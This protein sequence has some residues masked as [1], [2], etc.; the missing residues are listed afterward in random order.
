MS[1]PGYICCRPT[2]CSLRFSPDHPSLG[3]LSPA[4]QFNPFSPPT[5]LQR[6]K[7]LPT[8]LWHGAAVEVAANLEAPVVSPKDIE[9]RVSVD[10]ACL[11]EANLLIQETVEVINN[12]PRQGKLPVERERGRHPLVP[13][14]SSDREG[15]VGNLQP[16]T[17]LASTS[18]S[19]AK[20]QMYR[21]S[22]VPPPLK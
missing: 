18:R 10:P 13:V 12:M 11:P 19:V 22:R 9:S 1:M 2:M 15:F 14:V 3:T 6:E 8:S 5:T 20:N 21:P 7:T 4:R 17:Q 16:Q